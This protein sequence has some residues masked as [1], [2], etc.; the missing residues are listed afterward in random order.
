MTSNPSKATALRTHTCGELNASHA[1]QTVTLTGWTDVK[2]NHGGVLFINLRDL[3]GV[4]QVV[5]NP[6]SPVFKAAEEA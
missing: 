3:Y 2:R 5:A 6:G 4:T 1:G